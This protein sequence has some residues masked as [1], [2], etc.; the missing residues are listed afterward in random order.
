VAIFLIAIL[1][2]SII[3]IHISLTN[4]FSKT[5][6]GMEKNDGKNSGYFFLNNIFLPKL[7]CTKE[8]ISIDLDCD[9]GLGSSFL[10]GAFSL[11][12]REINPTTQNF[13]TFNEIQSRVI[14]FD[15]SDLFSRDVISIWEYMKEIEEQSKNNI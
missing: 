13:Y 12:V 9:Y 7:N 4:D 11:I 8:M 6:F 1:I 5:P 14:F 2:W 3:V 10:T 15:S